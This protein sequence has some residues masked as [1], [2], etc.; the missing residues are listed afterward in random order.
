MDFTR[1]R[2][3][4]ILIEIRFYRQAPGT[5][6]N[7]TTMPLLR[8]KHPRQNERNAICG[9][10]WGWMVPA[11]GARRCPAAVAAGADAPA[12]GRRGLDDTCA[13]GV[14]WMPGKVLRV[15]AGDGIESKAEFTEQRPWWPA[16]EQG[17][18][19]AVRAEDHVWFED[20]WM[21]ASLCDE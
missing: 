18:V 17:A 3:D 7:F 1:S 5:I 14:E 6:L 12:K 2:K 11:R 13:R 8:T 16:V 20:R 19:V 10:G 9:L 15:L 4:Q 21:V